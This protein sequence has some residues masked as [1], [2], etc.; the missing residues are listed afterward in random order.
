MSAVLTSTDHRS[1][2]YVLAPGE[3]RRNPT[4]W[5][6]IKAA[7]E[8]GPACTQPSHAGARGA[9]TVRAAATR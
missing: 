4:T 6:G 2:A 1:Q 9:Q 5:P 7:T 8:F 3:V